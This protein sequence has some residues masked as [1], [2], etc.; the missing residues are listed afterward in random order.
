[1]GCICSI[2]RTNSPRAAD[3]FH[4]AF[5]DWNDDLAVPVNRADGPAGDHA[6]VREVR[7]P[8]RDEH[9]AI[10]QTREFQQCRYIFGLTANTHH[11]LLHYRGFN[12]DDPLTLAKLRTLVNQSAELIREIRAGLQ[13]GSLLPPMTYRERLTLIEREFRQLTARR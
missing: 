1:M 6:V 13:N 4:N 2:P 5:I 11:L 10:N 12:R 3:V 7:S 8:S 9:D